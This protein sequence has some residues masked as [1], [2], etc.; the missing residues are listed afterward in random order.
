MEIEKVIRILTIF[1]VVAAF[2]VK[3]TTHLM[4]PQSPHGFD[5][6]IV[7]VLVLCLTNIWRKTDKQEENSNK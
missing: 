2:A 1:L 4:F 5:L 6:P 3:V 7:I